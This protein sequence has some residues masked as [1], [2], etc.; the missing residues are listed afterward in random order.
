MKKKTSQQITE[1]LRKKCVAKAKEISK[2]KSKYICDYCGIGKPQRMVHSHHIF[3][4]G[5][6]KGMSAD[7]DN[8]ITLCWLHHLGGLKFVSTKVF[9]FHSSPSDATAWFEDKYPER[10][11]KLKL[12]ARE[13]IKCDLI[14]W[15]KKYEGLTEMLKK[16]V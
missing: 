14:Y 1:T 9:S 7:L 6:N 4:E 12:R 2:I 15:Q 13:Y 5:L 3:S 8:L 16:V 10:Y 11:Q